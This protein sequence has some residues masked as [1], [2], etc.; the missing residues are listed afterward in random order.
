MP[1]GF[2]AR[3]V[4]GYAAAAE[5]IASAIG[6]IQSR[7]T[8]SPT[9]IARKAAVEALSCDQTMV[10]DMAAEFKKRRDCIVAA[11]NAVDG[12]RCFLPESAF[13]VFPNV[14]GIYGRSFGGKVIN[15]SADFIDY[16]LDEANV[17]DVPGAAFGGDSRI[18]LSYAASLKNIEEG[19]RR[20][21]DAVSKLT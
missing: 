8:S 7:N 12:I 11:L 6:K 14:S 2:R 19:I 18:R 17:A 5:E 21:R 9:S 16:L 1:Y 4:I 15:G 3:D 10:G 20:I 13:Y